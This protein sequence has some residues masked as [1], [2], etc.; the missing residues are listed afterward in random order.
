LAAEPRAE[1]PAAKDMERRQVKRRADLNEGRGQRRAIRV[2]ITAVL[3]GSLLASC[4]GGSESLPPPSSQPAD[5][6][7]ILQP[8]EIRSIMELAARATPEQVRR[9]S[10]ASRPTS[11]STRRAARRPSA[12]RAAAAARP[13]AG[14]QAPIVRP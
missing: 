9:A 14:V 12:S 11:R 10:S 8:D 1:L 4:G 2:G 13:L 5:T 6:A 3:L 7:P